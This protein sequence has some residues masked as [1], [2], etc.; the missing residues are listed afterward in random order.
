LPFYS[1]DV[2]HFTYRVAFPIDA[3]PL[4]T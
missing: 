4:T 1:S 3:D 2:Q